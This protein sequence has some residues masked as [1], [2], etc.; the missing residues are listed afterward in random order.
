MSCEHCEAVRSHQPRQT[1]RG[2]L[3]LQMSYPAKYFSGPESPGQ[4]DGD[5]GSC[6]CA[7]HDIW[8]AW[9]HLIGSAW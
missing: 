7:C 3:P 6:E 1:E 9:K 5:P 4:Y 8:R 2:Q